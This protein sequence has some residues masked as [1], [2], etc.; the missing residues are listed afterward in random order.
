MVGRKRRGRVAFLEDI[1]G[2][3]PEVCRKRG[4]T[5]ELD[6]GLLFVEC[7]ASEL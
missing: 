2:E 5:G 4:G 7:A 1:G 3:M 6:A